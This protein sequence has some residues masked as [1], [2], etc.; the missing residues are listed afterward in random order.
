M[1]CRCLSKGGGIGGTTVSREGVRVV[2][3]R[4]EPDRPAN[5]DEA[6]ERTLKSKREWAMKNRYVIFLLVHHS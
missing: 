6:R 1:A 3:D 2:A 5:D 4:A